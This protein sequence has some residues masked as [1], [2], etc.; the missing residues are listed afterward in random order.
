MEVDIRPF[1]FEHAEGTHEKYSACPLNAMNRDMVLG[2][3]VH[4]T[5]RKD[6]PIIT[7]QLALDL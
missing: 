2:I 1:L 7:V 4:L 5:I 6:V 3:L